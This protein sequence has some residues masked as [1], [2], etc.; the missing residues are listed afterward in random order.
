MKNY[1]EAKD[2]AS[3]SDHPLILDVRRGQEGMSG[4]ELFLKKHV[5]GAYYMDLEEDL[6]GPE[7][8]QSG[9]HPLPKR[10]D[11][12]KKLQFMGAV[13]NQSIIIYDDGDQFVAARAWFVLKYF[14]IQDV[15]IVQGGFPALVQENVAMESGHSTIKQG[16]IQLD[17]RLDLTLEFEGLKRL[18]SKNDDNTI[19]VDARSRERYLGLNEPL[20]SMA[21]HIPGAQSYPYQELLDE[22]F[23]LKSQADIQD[24]LQPLMGKDIILSCGSGV[25]AAL[26]MI[27]LD[28]INQ[29]ARLYPGSYSE[30]IKRRQK[31]ERIDQTQSSSSID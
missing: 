10:S 30:W 25:T 24:F 18:I 6:S 11:F 29:P 7:T 16:T 5:L 1:I 20:Y 13:N 23:H 17:E 28:E 19:L 14:G 22:N 4:R 26:V 9:A 8:D 3:R 27:A 31:V 15:K 12:Q 21:G 2:L